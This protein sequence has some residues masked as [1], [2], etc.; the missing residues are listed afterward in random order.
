MSDRVDASQIMGWVLVVAAGA[1]VVLSA[2]HHWPH[3]GDDGYIF[4]RHAERLLVGKWGWTD[5]V[6]PLEGYSSP[7]WL[8][9]L[10]GLAAVGMATPLA[11]KILGALS[12]GAVLAGMWALVRQLGGSIATVGFAWFILALLR[13]LPFWTFAG[14][15]TPLAAALII[16]TAWGLARGQG[17]WAA[18]TGLLGLVRPEGPALALLVVLIAW[19]RGR[20][21]PSWAALAGALGPAAAWL[22]L[23]LVIYGDVLPNTFYAKAA[24]QP[25]AQALRGLTYAGWL[26]PVV[27]L[28]LV[29]LVLGRK[30]PTWAAAAAVFALAALQLGVV[31]GGGG[32]WMW[33]GR[34]LVPVFPPVIALIAWAALAEGP[35]RYLAW[36]LPLGLAPWVT[37]PPAWRDV[38]TLQPMATAT[39]QEGEMTLAE[40]AAG[41]WL[42]Q[43]GQ[44][45]DLVAVNH[46]GALPW[47][48]PELRFLDMTGLLDR[49]IAGHATGG[50]HSKYDVDHV[51]AQAPAWVVLH[52][53]TP[54]TPQ[55]GIAEADYWVGETA[56]LEDPRFHEAYEPTGE[57]W[58]WEWVV[59]GPSWTVVYRRRP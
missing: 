45:G 51:L 54:P 13:P 26:T 15:E 20:Q 38:L 31:I 57:T 53:R 36:I 40:A 44:P 1:L 29:M 3:Q 7:L 34:L 58:A 25:I 55:G 59:E 39:W 17:R 14:L 32:D 24:G 56:L 8:G 12:L 16:W 28:L 6:A 46:A 33:F 22:V 27:V 9:G 50:L 23:R 5:G 10:T 42:Q 11:A 48:A 18:P 41:R 2:V 49:H 30:R 52:T 37:P 21:R 43:N 19:V 4:F 47:A 35:T